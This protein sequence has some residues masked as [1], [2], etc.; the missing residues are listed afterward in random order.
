MKNLFAIFLFVALF[1][2]L[3]QNSFAQNTISGVVFD[4][5]R[6][7]VGKIDVEL[8]DEF[9]RLL[10]S[11]KTA[12]SGLYFFQGLRAGIY[13]VQ[14]RVDG[15]NYKSV[16]ERIQL[17]QTNRTTSTGQ[18]SGSESMQVNFSLETDR[19][20]NNQ[21]PL[22]NEVVFAQNVPKEAE[23]YFENALKK[24]DDKKQEE[25]ISDL[26]NALRIFPEYYLALDKIGYEYL[27]K[28]KFAE[29]ES[30]FTKALQVYPKSFSSKSGLGIAQYKLGKK[31]EA[32]K[33]LEES[34]VLDPSL[35]SSFLFLGK[36]YRELKE[37]EKAETNLKKA[38]DL[39]KN[40]IA[41]VHWELALLYYYNLNRPSDAADELELYLKAKPDAPNKAQ[42][43]KLIRQMREKAKEKS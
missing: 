6:K 14:V 32:V 23:K 17:G 40:K 30:A 12:A 1:F 36:I 38:K 3:Y 28:G 2:V 31:Q 19:R 8:L 41:D 39:S 7:P 10:K 18:T 9:E 43:E 21:T 11:T 5:A 35:A 29:S 16:K 13:Y 27:A 42:I 37:Y 34:I 20:N 33:T 4:E 22:S 26:E 24:L 25:A 15:T